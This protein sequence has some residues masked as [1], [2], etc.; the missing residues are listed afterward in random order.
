[1]QFQDY[2]L[3][4]SKEYF[5]DKWL[6]QTKLYFIKIAGNRARLKACWVK[7]LDTKPEDLSSIPGFYMEKRATGLL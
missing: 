4:V 1:M 7:V 6:H 2:N 5:R 3:A